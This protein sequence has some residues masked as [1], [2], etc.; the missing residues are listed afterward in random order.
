GLELEERT[1][2]SG[3][4]EL[5]LHRAQLL[6]AGQQQRLQQRGGDQ[7]GMRPAG[8]GTLVVL[9]E[10]A[11]SRDPALARGLQVGQQAEQVRPP[12]AE[13]ELVVAE[14]QRPYFKRNALIRTSYCWASRE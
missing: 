11:P 5:E 10:E 2:R 9:L 7:P 8:L 6:T 14:G 1:D 3:A 12:A 13:A 4:R